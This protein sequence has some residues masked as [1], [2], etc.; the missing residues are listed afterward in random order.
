MITQFGLH[1]LI[2]RVLSGNLLTIVMY[3]AVVKDPLDVKDWCFIDSRLFREQI[4]YLKKHFEIIPL[5]KA[6]EQ[7]RNGKITYPTAA[8]TFD[9]GFQNNYDIAFPILR[10]AGVP[11][12][13][14]L[15]TGFTDTDDTIWFCRLN[16]ALA[17]TQKLSLKWKGQQF[18]LNGS[19]RKSEIS[20]TLQNKLKQFSHLNLLK[21]LRQLILELG[22]DPDSPVPVDSPF[23][24]LSYN[25]IKEM[26]DSGLI[27]FGAHTHSHAILSLLSLQ[28]R[29]EQVESSLEAVQKLT[30]CP[31]D[32]FAYPNGQ[33]QDYDV[34]TIMLLNELGVRY[35]VTTIKGP[36][37][38][39]TPLMELRRY[40]IGVDMNLAEFKMDVH[41]LIIQL[42]RLS[43]NYNNEML[44]YSCR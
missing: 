20:V 35:A 44:A 37:D 10:N 17:K 32:L 18:N 23:R 16:N 22:E 12:T 21:E 11:A 25:A 34:E 7:C 33:A 26:I 36:N 28:E 4:A 39:R 41:H 3:H 19:M 29:R 27:E 40:G 31:C 8:I 5:S 1:R 42:K 43:N 13:V 2:N 24:M 30:G 38:L 9:D 6:I 14:F 15:T